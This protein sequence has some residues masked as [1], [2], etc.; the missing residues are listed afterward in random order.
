MGGGEGFWGGRGGGVWWWVVSRTSVGVWRARF[1]EINTRGLVAL[2]GLLWVEEV[3]HGNW[4]GGGVGFFLAEKK[5]KGDQR[6]REF[7]RCKRAVLERRQ[8]LANRNW[9]GDEAERVS[10][11]CCRA[12]ERRGG[13]GREESMGFGRTLRVG[14][15]GPRQTAKRK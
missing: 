13:G 8:R 3:W 4:S 7:R 15:G 1:G 6:R 5:K 9:T 10:R 11:S 14:G 2:G 12:R